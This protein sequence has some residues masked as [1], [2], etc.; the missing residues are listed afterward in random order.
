MVEVVASMVA[1][2]EREAADTEAFYRALSRDADDVAVEVDGRS[3]T[4][5]GILSGL[6]AT[7]L[8]LQ[9]YLA[10]I[11]KDEGGDPAGDDLERF[12]RAVPEPLVDLPREALLERRASVRRETISRLWTLQ[13]ADL[14]RV[15][16]HGLWG[17]DRVEGLI[18]WAGE[19]A[20]HRVHAVRRALNEHGG[21]R[22]TTPF[23]DVDLGCCH[24][25]LQEEIALV[26]DADPLVSQREFPDRLEALTS[27][28]DEDGLRWRP[29]AGEWSVLEVLAHLVHSEIVYGFR[30]RAIV[31]SPRSALAG[32]DQEAWVERLPEARFGREALLGH[33]RALKELNVACL[34]RLTADDRALW[35]VHGE[36]G[37]ESVEALVGAIA[38]HDILHER[39]IEAT[40]RAH[41]ADGGAVGTTDFGDGAAAQGGSEGEGGGGVGP[42]IEPPG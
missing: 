34:E 22:L 41:A 27:A 40:L 20:R 25:I 4:V 24:P 14:E 11:A 26:G 42:E 16:R 8:W 39:Q 10:A 17:E 3:L 7:E 29:A 18:R 2:L 15:V 13:P 9:R 5:R 33:L 21:A 31:A 1:E 32:Y 38:G 23:V 19:H 28:V 6:I 30:Y 35:A 36:R 12:D 37:P